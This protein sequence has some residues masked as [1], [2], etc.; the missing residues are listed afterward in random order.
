MT[1]GT[2]KDVN[3]FDC[4]LIED[5]YGGHELNVVLKVGVPEA[6]GV[7]FAADYDSK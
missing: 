7:P 2:S 6:F 1:F 5:G 3:R 4:Y